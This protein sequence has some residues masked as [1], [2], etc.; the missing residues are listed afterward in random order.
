MSRWNCEEDC[1]KTL[2]VFS[3]KFDY[4][5]EKLKKGKIGISMIGSTSNRTGFVVP[6]VTV[7]SPNE[8]RQGHKPGFQISLRHLQRR[9]PYADTCLLPHTTRGSRVSNSRSSV[10][11]CMTCSYQM[12]A[13]GKSRTIPLSSVKHIPT[14]SQ[15]IAQ[16]PVPCLPS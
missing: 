2:H 12:P 4:N 6:K 15:I 14:S 9:L 16:L 1:I 11:I 3:R 13:P 8:Y 5:E 10:C 7:R